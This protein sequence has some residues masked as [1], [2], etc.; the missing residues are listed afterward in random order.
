EGDGG[1]LATIDD[2]GDFVSVAVNLVGFA[3]DDLQSVYNVLNSNPADF[4]NIVGRQHQ[5]LLNELLSMRLMN[6][7][8]QDPAT[9]YNGQ[10]TIDQTNK[11]YRGDSQGGIFGTTYM[12]VSTDVTRGVLGEPGAPYSLLLNRSHDFAPFFLFIKFA[13]PSG[14]EI[15]HMLGL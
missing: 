4:R 3:H 10:P 15:Q 8:A 5:G 6:A 14:R 11:Y 2:Q 9:F 7:L 1:Y 12:S 13:Y